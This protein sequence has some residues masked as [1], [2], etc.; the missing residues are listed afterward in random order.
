MN[1]NMILVISLVFRRY[2]LSTRRKLLILFFAIKTIKTGDDN[3][4]C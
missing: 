4:W 2:C 1:K 3:G